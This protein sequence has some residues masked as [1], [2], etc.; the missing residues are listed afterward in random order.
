MSDQSEIIAFLSTPAAFETGAEVEVIET[1]GAFVFLCGDTALKLKRAVKYDYMDMSTV[2]LRRAMLLREIELNL[3]AAPMIYRD[4]L[5]VTRGDTGFALGGDGPVVDWVLRMWRFPSEN[6]FEEIV[7]RG[8]L[9][10]RL[11]AETGA[12]IAEYHAAAPVIRRA[13]DQ[14]IE[15]ILGELSRVFAEFPGAAGTGQVGTW[16]EDAGTAF[17]RV[18]P[19]LAARGRDGHVRRGHGDL[20]LRN[21]VLIEGQPVLFDALE[22]D[23]E[24]G[25]CDVLYDTAFLVLDLCHHSLHAQACRVLDSWLSEMRGKEDSGLAALPLF[26]SVRAAIRAMVILQTDAARGSAG[27]SAAEVE[28]YLDIAISALSPRPPVL[29]AV[30]GYS[31]TGKSRLAERLAP[32]LG[33]LPGAVILSSD[34]ERKAGLAKEIRLPARSYTE[35]RRGAVYDAIMNR[36]EKILRAGHSAILDATFL[37]TDRRDQA[38]D[39]A[40][41]LGVPFHGFWLEAP[42]STL[43]ARIRAR[44]ASASDADVEILRRQI[45]QS[46][47]SIEWPRLDAS[48]GLPELLQR[49]RSMID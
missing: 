17:E 15:N 7:A 36:A 43:E 32:G 18:R 22:F 25:T 33:A 28:A 35:A 23:E 19:L 38:R 8:E 31:G 12:K 26:L 44:R 16:L 27:A 6:E 13:G 29:I 30:G 1:H 45:E 21:L 5:P 9:G 41:H 20:H 49:A 10:D 3:P 2:E 47:G 39:L 46:L 42:R 11:S 24:L 37:D 48:C 14:L 40:R 4:V 34:I